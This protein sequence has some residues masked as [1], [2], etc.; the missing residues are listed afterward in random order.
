DA[1]VDD[2]LADAQLDAAVLRE[3]PLRDVQVRED[4]E[5]RDQRGL[6]IRRWPHDLLQYTIDPV[7]DADLLLVALEVD[8][9]RAAGDCVIEDAVDELDDRSVLDLGLERPDAQLLLFLLR[10]Q[11]DVALLVELLEE[12]LHPLLDHVVLPLYHLP[13][14]ELPRDHWFD[15]EAGDELQVVD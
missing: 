2:A 9:R 15:L 14:G 5:A 7:T 11:L 3:T 6:H 1:K 10:D 8:V 13:Q 12:V 4:L